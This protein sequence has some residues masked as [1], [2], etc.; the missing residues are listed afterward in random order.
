MLLDDYEEELEEE[1]GEEEEDDI[2]D[3]E[4][5]SSK[6]GKMFKV[7]V[8]VKIKVK[9]EELVMVGFGDKFVEV[10]EW[11]LEYD[12]V[13][14]VTWK[15]GDATSYLYFVNIFEFIVEMMKRLEIVELLINV[16]WMILVS[17][18]IDFLVV[19]YLVLNIIYS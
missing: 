3:V 1:S 8:K 16:F 15:F 19:V 18:L 12:L 10:V 13:L 4:I 6:I 14:K 17:K 9:K 2:E 11:Y 7:K 5:G